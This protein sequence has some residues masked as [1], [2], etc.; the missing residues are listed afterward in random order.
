[1]ALEPEWQQKLGELFLPT[2]E[3]RAAKFYQLSFWA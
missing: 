2:E 1:M 3:R